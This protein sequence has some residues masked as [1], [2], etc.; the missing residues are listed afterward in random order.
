MIYQAC[1]QQLVVPRR[2]LGVVQQVSESESPIVETTQTVH[3]NRRLKK[4]LAGRSAW[5]IRPPE[6]F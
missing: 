5:R 4:Q 6:S 1:L 3:S 2:C